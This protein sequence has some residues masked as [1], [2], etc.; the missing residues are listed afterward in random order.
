M[1]EPTTQCSCERWYYCPNGRKPVA[2]LK[3]VLVPSLKLLSSLSAV[4][5]A[6]VA[7]AARRA[8]VSSRVFL[9]CPRTSTERAKLAGLTPYTA[10]GQTSIPGFGTTNW[11]ILE[12]LLERFMPQS[13]LNNARS[14]SQTIPYAFSQI[15]MLIRNCHAGPM[16]HSSNKKNMNLFSSWVVPKEIWF[17]VTNTSVK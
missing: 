1:R 7:W 10:A 4:A 8:G 9:I 5:V 12:Y 11:D 16:F 3:W 13:P 15:K 14:F 6:S 2:K 17:I